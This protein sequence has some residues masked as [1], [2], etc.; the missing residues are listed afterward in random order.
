MAQ[1]LGARPDAGVDRWSS[2][3]RPSS[4]A[5]A[6]GG[7]RRASFVTLPLIFAAVGLPADKIPI[8]LTI[9]WF[10][11]RCRTTSNVLGDMTVAV[12]LDRTAD[13]PGDGES[14]MNETHRSA[15]SS[16]SDFDG[17]TTLL[18]R[19]GRPSPAAGSS[20]A[21]C[22]RSSSAT[23]PR[24]GRGEPRRRDA[25]GVRH[26]VLL[27][28]PPSPA[29]LTPRPEAWIP[30]LIV[31]EREHG[32]GAAVALFAR[33]VEIAK[34]AACHRLTLESGYHRVRAHR[35]YGREGMTDARQVSS[36]W[37]CV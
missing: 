21:P 1:A 5:S 3:S 27:D 6:P 17:V 10:L 9:D 2:S 14:V 24:S 20:Q 32:R 34:D 30:D 33:A 22:V 26:R 25:A 13:S 11:D 37:N 4:R 12:L 8:L 28:P 19:L 35:F 18:A 29:E 7:S 23:S 16:R 15:A 31:T 36:S